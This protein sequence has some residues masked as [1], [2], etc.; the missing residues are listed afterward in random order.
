MEVISKELK[1]INIQQNRQKMMN[2]NC[3]KHTGKRCTQVKII[4]KFTCVTSQVGWNIKKKAR[5]SVIS[6]KN[7][8]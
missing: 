7:I 1:M 2:K 8:S 3:V 4:K 6:C 5:V